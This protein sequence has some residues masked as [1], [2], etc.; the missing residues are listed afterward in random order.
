MRLRFRPLGAGEM[1]RPPTQ[2]DQ[3]N[4]DD[5]DL[6]EALVREALQNSLDARSGADPVRVRFDIADLAGDAA[7]A[8]LQ[9]LDPDRLRTHL[10]A[11]GMLATDDDWTKVRLL[12]IEDFGTTG[13]EGSTNAMDH[14]A[15]ADFWRRMGLSHKRGNSLGRWGLGKLVFSSASGVRSFFGLTVRAADSHI[16]HLMGQAV[17]TTHEIRGERYDSH[18]FYAMHREDGMQVPQTDHARVNDF[19]EAARLTRTNQPGLSV[20]VPFAN[21][22]VS[23]ERILQAALRNYFFPILMNQLSLEVGGLEV[24]AATFSNLAEKHGG[25]RFS[26]GRLAGF[27]ETLRLARAGEMTPVQLDRKWAKENSRIEDCL[28]DRL[29]Q[30]RTDLAEGRPIFVRAPLLLK[31]ADGSELETHIDLFLQSTGGALGDTLFVRD[32]IVLSAEAKYFRG[33]NAFAALIAADTPVSSFL[34]DAEN[35]AHTSWSSSAEKLTANWKAPGLRLK[36]IRYSLQRL[37]SALYTS[38]ESVDSNAL[39][40]VFSIAAERGVKG[41]TPKRGT[42]SPPPTPPLPPATPKAFRLL[43]KSGG[44]ALRP[45]HALAPEQ[46]PIGIR[47]RTAY[48][49]LRGNPFAKHDPLD[50]DF[51]KGDIVITCRGATV[52]PQ[53]A[54]ILVADVGDPDFEIVVEGFDLQR[55][56]IVDPVRTS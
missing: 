50:F 41:G 56:L 4:N 47:V 11:S 44:F 13:L 37:Y 1:D 29:E 15:F 9:F 43:R 55:D 39:I 7:S 23:I 3:F 2:R 40:D 26:G 45:G 18:G 17:L 34:G 36:E 53:S 49:V 54:N 31:K 28:G 30:L 14:H 46:L 21:V 52:K 38:V 20:V 35:P 32:T 48:D 27:I 16:A 12:V 6:A 51:T 19:R 42:T 8:L 10:A 25:D 5:V 22:S 33:K 24:T